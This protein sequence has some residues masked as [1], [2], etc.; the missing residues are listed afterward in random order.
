MMLAGAA[1]GGGAQGSQGNP[2]TSWTDL[3]NQNLTNDSN[4]YLQLAGHTYKVAID[5]SGFA[6]F[7][8]NGNYYTRYYDTPRIFLVRLHSVRHVLQQGN[9]VQ[10]LYNL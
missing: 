8:I 3:R 1:G 9:Q 5:D 6:K 2:Y 7:N 4:N 10:L